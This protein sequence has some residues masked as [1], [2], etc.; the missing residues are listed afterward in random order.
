MFCKVLQL[1]QGDTVMNVHVAKHEKQIVTF[2]NASSRMR[3]N[4]LN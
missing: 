1:Y 4:S 2:I 3:T